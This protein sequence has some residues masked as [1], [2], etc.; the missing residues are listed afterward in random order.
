MAWVEDAPPHGCVHVMQELVST[1][2]QVH[3][4]HGERHDEGPVV[5]HGLVDRSQLVEVLESV[6]GY[7]LPLLLTFR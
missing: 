5:S 3:A 7:S 6:E 4:N 1:M 2:V